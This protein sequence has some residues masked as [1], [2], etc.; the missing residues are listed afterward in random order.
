MVCEEYSWLMRL[1][2]RSEVGLQQIERRLLDNQGR[3]RPEF[4]PLLVE[5][6]RIRAGNQQWSEAEDDLQNFFALAADHSKEVVAREAGLGS[7]D[8]G[9]WESSASLLQGFL[10][11]RRG[12]TT[13]AV[14]AWERGVRKM[15]DMSVFEGGSQ[16]MDKVILGALS[17]RLTDVQA[18]ALVNLLIQ[19][20]GTLQT[21]STESNLLSILKTGLFRIP[22]SALREAWLTPRG[23]EYARKIAFRDISFQEYLRSPFL[24]IGMEIARQSTAGPELSMEQDQV[25]WQAIDRFVKAY[26]DGKIGTVQIFLLASGWKGVSG[27]LGWKWLSHLDG[28][29]R[30]PLA[31]LLGLRCERL[32]K[33]DDAASLF[34][35][36]MDAAAGE[37]LLQ[38]L[39]HQKLQK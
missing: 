25:C 7:R 30:G 18:D 3:C 36:A 34:R 24:V 2:G 23:R 17:G 22:P 10:L 37:S 11:D 12:D 6:A 21:M 15:T 31:Y 5:R 13:A 39:A 32:K 28:D 9:R 19:R 29:L 4:A 20:S 1:Q 26:Y 38:Q 27:P 16:V 8:W 33:A 35:I 14:A